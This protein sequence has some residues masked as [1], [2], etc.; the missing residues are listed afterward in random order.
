MHV[1]WS[2]N[3]CVSTWVYH[4]CQLYICIFFC[5][6]FLPLLLASLYTFM[7]NGKSVNHS[8]SKIK[9]SK[10]WIIS[11]SI[12]STWA[13]AIQIYIY[14]VCRDFVSFWLSTLPS[15]WWMLPCY[16]RHVPALGDENTRGRSAWWCTS[17]SLW[18]SYKALP[19]WPSLQPLFPS[20]FVWI[21]SF[22]TWGCIT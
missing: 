18:I 15:G 5:K 22:Q 7:T 4:I 17:S 13:Q 19:A 10:T 1:I 20:W 12:P 8:V 9:M 21:P 16:W 14:V 2:N 3:K 11:I 6:G